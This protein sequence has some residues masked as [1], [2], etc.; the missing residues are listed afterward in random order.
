[1]NSSRPKRLNRNRIVGAFWSL[2]HGFGDKGRTKLRSEMQ[3]QIEVNEAIPPEERGIEHE[4]AIREAQDVLACVDMFEAD[5]TGMLRG[6]GIP[7]HKGGRLGRV[8]G[9]GTATYTP[10]PEPEK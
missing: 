7:G 2:L 4:W 8:V 3:R 5:L 9:R 1:M 10:P 6:A